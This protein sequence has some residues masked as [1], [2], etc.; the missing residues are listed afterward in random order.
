MQVIQQNGY[1]NIQQIS[2]KDNLADYSPKQS[3][4]SLRNWFTKLECD[5]LET[6]NNID[7]RGSTRI[8]SSHE[9]GEQNS[10]S[11]ITERSIEILYQNYC[12]DNYYYELIIY[13]LFFPLLGFYPKGFFL[14]R[15]LMR[16]I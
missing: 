12:S 16:H 4:A 5:D 2:L 13:V 14:V 8:K 6:F 10:N 15:F 7:K 11:S 3:T 1:I 9:Q